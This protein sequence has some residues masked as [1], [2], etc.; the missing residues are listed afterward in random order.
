[1]DKHALAM[2]AKHARSGAIAGLRWDGG[3]KVVVELAGG[4]EE[5]EQQVD[6][7]EDGELP[8]LLEQAVP[9]L[10]EGGLPL[11]GVLDPLYLAAA[12]PHLKLANAAVPA[13]AAPAL[14]RIR[15]PRAGD[16]LE[17]PSY[18]YYPSQPGRQLAGMDVTVCGEGKATR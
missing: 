16:Q 13:A 12:P 11:R 7:A 10:V 3:R 8:G 2:V 18:H 9:A 15:K 4:G 14:A 6:V 1:M 17:L 5:E